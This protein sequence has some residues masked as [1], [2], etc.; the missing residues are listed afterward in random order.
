MGTDAPFMT[1]N[2]LFLTF[3]VLLIA[4]WD[5][6]QFWLHG[7]EGTITLQLWN[8]DRRFPLTSYSVSF[9]MGCLAGHLFLRG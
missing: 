8:L 4:A 3:I 9:G 2:T 6:Y 5:V 1:A 7:P